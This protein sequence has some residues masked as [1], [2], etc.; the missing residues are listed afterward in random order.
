MGVE[1]AIYGDE[2]PCRKLTK[3]SYEIRSFVLFPN[4]LSQLL[5]IILM[6]VMD[7]D[8]DYLTG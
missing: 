6:S 1:D 3:N 2:S 8:H 5:Q 7:L 4:E